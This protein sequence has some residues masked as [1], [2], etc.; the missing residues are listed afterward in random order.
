MKLLTISGLGYNL[1]V[2]TQD[3]QKI[4]EHIQ[5]FLDSDFAPAPLIVGE[6]EELQSFCSYV[7]PLWKN[8]R[9]IPSMEAAAEEGD[10]QLG[11]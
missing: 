2:V 5:E 3:V 8:L 11:W 10:F 7:K 1:K 6:E 4:R 9:V